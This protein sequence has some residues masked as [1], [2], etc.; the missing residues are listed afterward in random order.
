MTASVISVLRFTYW[1]ENTVSQTQ[2]EET[3]IE[4]QVEVQTEE[5]KQNDT[6]ILVVSFGTSYNDNRDLTIGAIETA[7]ADTFPEYEV[8]RAF[9][10]QIIIDKLKERDK[11]EIDNVEEALDR[12]AADGIRELIVQPT[13][14]MDGYEYH[15]LAKSLTDY[16]EK[17]DK[18]M[19]NEKIGSS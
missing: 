2:K 8:R 6:A 10:S 17:F 3:Q 13:H 16:L 12:A 11:L 7:I 9:T 19:F 18:I 1:Q 15:D 4:T 14:L 5:P